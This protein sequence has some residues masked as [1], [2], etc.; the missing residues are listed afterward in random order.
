[1][2]KQLLSLILLMLSTVCFAEEPI[3]KGKILFTSRCGNCHKINE[4]FVGPALADVEK[5]RKSE[6]IVDFIQSSQTMVK[7]G[8]P[9]AVALFAKFKVP[10]P[11]H[12]DLTDNDVSN[13][14]EYIKNESKAVA[15]IVKAPFAK[16]TPPPS[17]YAGINFHESKG[18]LISILVAIALLIGTIFFYAKVKNFE[19]SKVW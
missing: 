10:M 5:R 7:S 12:K 4:V 15:N 13:L 18:V 8:D 11:D 2:K 17:G 14:I 9:D 1:M 3:E 16:P 6:W 19:D